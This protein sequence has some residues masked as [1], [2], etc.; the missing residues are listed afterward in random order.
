MTSRPHRYSLWQARTADFS[1]IRRLSCNLTF[2]AAARAGQVAAG[3][4]LQWPVRGVAAS[5]G[6][7]RLA[8]R[9]GRSAV[10]SIPPWGGKWNR[11][12]WVGWVKVDP[13]LWLLQGP[14]ARAIISLDS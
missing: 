13:G 4:P 11:E 3:F 6:D 10:S 8:P 9:R 7:R 14:Q 1:D 12:G 5:Q 2:V